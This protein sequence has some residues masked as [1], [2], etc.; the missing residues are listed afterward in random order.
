MAFSASK[1][2]IEQELVFQ[3]IYHEPRVRGSCR[4]RVLG[5]PDRLTYTTDSRIQL[6]EGGRL[7]V[8][9]KGPVRPVAAGAC[10][11][12]RRRGQSECGDGEVFTPSTFAFRNVGE[13][14]VTSNVCTQRSSCTKEC[15]TAEIRKAILL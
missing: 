2:V 10:W 3:T 15:L 4:R 9:H 6:E 13:Q 7:G 1:Q 14:V 8:G 11:R 12:R 5:A